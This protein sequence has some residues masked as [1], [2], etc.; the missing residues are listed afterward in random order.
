MSAEAIELEE[1]EYT[2][3]L[4]APVFLRILGLLKPHWVW[5][6]GF[7]IAI[8]LTSVTDAYF[9][10]LNKQFVDEGIRMENTAR[11][12]QLATIYGTIILFQILDSPEALPAVVEHVL[13]SFR[14][15]G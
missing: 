3:Q 1:E 15:A 6:L 5:A 13:G 2:S 8:A 10:Y 4:T 7:F 11:L 14:Y 9:T 12:I